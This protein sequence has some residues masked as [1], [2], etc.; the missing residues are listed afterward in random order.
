M[1]ERI[2]FLKYID[3]LICVKKYGYNIIELKKVL[4]LIKVNF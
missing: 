3:D 1:D 2:L 4:K